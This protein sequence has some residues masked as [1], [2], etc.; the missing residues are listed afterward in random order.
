MCCTVSAACE[1]FTHAHIVTFHAHAL[2]LSIHCV[3]DPH[4]THTLFDAYYTHN[5]KT[6][7]YAM[8]IPDLF[9]KR[10]EANGSWSLFCPNEAPGLA[11]CHGDAFETLYTRYT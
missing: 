2:T 1:A 7:F 11:D 9:M 5:N 4:Y 8:W 10:V 3:T 6:V